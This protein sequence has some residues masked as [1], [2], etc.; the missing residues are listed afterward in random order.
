VQ[1]VTGGI[2]DN[3]SHVGQRESNY[4]QKQKLFIPKSQYIAGRSEQQIKA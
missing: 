1:T 3:F 4:G 2:S